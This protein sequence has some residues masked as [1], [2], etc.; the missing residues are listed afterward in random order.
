MGRH[1][2]R[3]HRSTRTILPIFPTI[4]NRPGRFSRTTYRRPFSRVLAQRQ[5]YAIRRQRRQRIRQRR[6]RERIGGH[7]IHHPQGAGL[8][9][10]WECGYPGTFTWRLN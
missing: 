2:S 9:A 8:A 5:P 1:R 6:D 4:P 7:G 10:H 3:Q